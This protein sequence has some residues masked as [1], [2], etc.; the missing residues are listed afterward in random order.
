MV[1]VTN[2]GAVAIGVTSVGITGDSGWCGW[3]TT[4][5]GHEPGGMGY[6]GFVYEV[7]RGT[8]WRADCWGNLAPG[9][10]A[11]SMDVYPLML[12][13]S[14]LQDVGWPQWPVS[15]ETCGTP[16]SWQRGGYD[17]HFILDRLSSGMHRPSM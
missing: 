1:T 9:G 8:G 17:L 2:A 6:D 15:L 3:D 12:A 7:K 13:R 11:H 4:L 14:G 10:S 16:G 5:L